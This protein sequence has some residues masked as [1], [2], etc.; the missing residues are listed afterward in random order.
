MISALGSS[1]LS[2]TYGENISVLSINK[3]FAVQV[4]KGTAIIAIILSFIGKLTA[5]I[6]TIPDSVIGGV[7]I[8]LFGAIG[9]TE[10]QDYEY[11]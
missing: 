3:V 7:S 11:W 1:I 9:I 10:L 2:T 4:L 6:Q 5:L 8:F